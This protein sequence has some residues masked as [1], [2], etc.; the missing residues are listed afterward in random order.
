MLRKNLQVHLSPL[1]PPNLAAESNFIGRS[2]SVRHKERI[3]RTLA[4][5]RE[6][7]R[8]ADS[9]LTPG[10]GQSLSTI[11]IIWTRTQ[12]KGLAGLDALASGALMLQAVR[13]AAWL[14]FGAEKGIT[15]G[16]NRCRG[17]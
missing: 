12:P 11:Y 16:K 14:A 8:G 1:F 4:L 7:E 17:F 10:F 13:L 2:A 9:M 5:T 15:I 3:T 6:A